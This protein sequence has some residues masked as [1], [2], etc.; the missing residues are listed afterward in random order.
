MDRGLTAT[1]YALLGL[2]TLR[3]EWSAYDLVQQSQRNLRF[4]WPRAESK[5]YESAKR[6]VDL[7]L[8]T[9]KQRPTGRRRR[10]IYSITPAGR[11]A[12]RAW[13]REPGAGPA[14]QFEGAL[15]LFFVDHGTKQDALAT[16]DAIDEW[17]EGV[18]A[19][20]TAIAR[21]YEETDAGPF[22]QRLHVNAL[23]T[24]LIWRH[25]ETIEDWAAWARQQIADWDGTGPQPQRHEVDMQAWLRHLS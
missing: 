6:L 12:L 25:L 11:R 23:F 18:R 20:A 13:L 17:A 19:Q 8:A 4:M 7:G 1:N 9:T 10:T 22:P 5:V 16:M 24:E 21:E 15:K 14:L 2:L 3:S